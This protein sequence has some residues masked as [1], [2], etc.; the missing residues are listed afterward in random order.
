MEGERKKRRRASRS[1]C[2]EEGRSDHHSHPVTWR[3]TR[4]R[5]SHPSSAHVLGAAQGL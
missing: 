3:V 5:V 1:S 4:S 2:E